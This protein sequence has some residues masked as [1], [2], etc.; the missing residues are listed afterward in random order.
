MVTW[1]GNEGR[2]LVP[3]WEYV[4]RT[5]SLPA[6]VDVSD[7]FY[8]VD[9]RLRA[10]EREIRQHALRV[11]ADVIEVVPPDVLDRR[12][13][14]LIDALVSNLGHTAPAVRRASLH[15]LQAYLGRSKK[16][17]VIVRD[18]I[19]SAVERRIADDVAVGVVLSTPSL[20]VSYGAS[21]TTVRCAL[22]VLT[23]VLS[24][25]GLREPALRS[26]ARL[27][28]LLGAERFGALL[29][30]AETLPPASPKLVVDT[31]VRFPQTSLAMTVL[32]ES[33]H[34]S[35]YAASD[36]DAD[37][38]VRVLSDSDTDAP[39]WSR[40]ARRVR[41][42]GEVVKLRTPDS[43]STNI[44]S[45]TDN[46]ITLVRKQNGHLSPLVMKR[47]STGKSLIPKPVKPVSNRPNPVKITG[48][49]FYY[50]L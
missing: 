30:L 50:L 46:E 17:D 41:F 26:L 3:L 40:T 49:Y 9:D 28:D 45:D 44:A 37:C 4:V 35:D 5:H 29:P 38:I 42:G 22:S 24:R 32:E 13:G 8:A 19:R 23:E 34:S 6:N 15:S 7:V 12:M 11:L 10:P 39:H 20:L 2:G 33:C 14:R 43:D 48:K 47:P 18:I 16:A 21:S 25:S 1:G 31:E 27:R 36:D